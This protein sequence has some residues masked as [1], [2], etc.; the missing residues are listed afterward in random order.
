[1]IFYLGH[2][3]FPTSGSVTVSSCILTG[4][5]KGGKNKRM[6]KKEGETRKGKKEGREKKE[7]KKTKRKEG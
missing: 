7:V 1:M 6:K 2:F 4:R 3:N 5:R